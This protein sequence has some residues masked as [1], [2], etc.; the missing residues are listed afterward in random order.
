MKVLLRA[1]ILHGC[2]LAGLWAGRE[3]VPQAG[4]RFHADELVVRF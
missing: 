4:E 1:C 2:L 3:F